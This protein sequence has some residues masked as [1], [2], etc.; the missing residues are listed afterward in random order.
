[1][2]NIKIS[3]VKNYKY[4]AKNHDSEQIENLKKSIETFGFLVPVILDKDNVLITGHARVKAV[5]ELGWTEMREN[6]ARA[7]KGEKFVPFFYADDLSK[8][9]IANFR[10]ADNKLNESSWNY[11]NL[12]VEVANIENLIGFDADELDMI[13]N[14]SNE[15]LKV[16]SEINGGEFGNYTNDLIANNKGNTGLGADALQGDISGI[17]FPVTFW[18]ETEELQKQVLM[19]FSK[20]GSKIGVDEKKLLEMLG[21]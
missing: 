15:E 17:R 6:V 13:V 14:R 1:M 19:F 3:E 9:E 12:R 16:I 11:E 18:F 21:I 8:E 2:A 5:K 4:N 7:K 20:N 10:I